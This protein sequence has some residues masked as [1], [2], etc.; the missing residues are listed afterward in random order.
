MCIEA[1]GSHPALDA[2]FDAVTLG[3]VIVQTTLGTRPVQLD[4][5]HKLTLRDVTYKGSTAIR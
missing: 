1:S 3:G 5:S 4:A 2:C